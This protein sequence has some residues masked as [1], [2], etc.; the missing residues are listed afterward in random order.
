[1]AI[2][3]LSMVATCKAK[4]TKSEDKKKSGQDKWKVETIFSK[5]RIRASNVI[6]SHVLHFSPSKFI[7]LLSSLCLGVE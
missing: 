5:E 3:K 1:V 2:D 4:F 7:P 6:S